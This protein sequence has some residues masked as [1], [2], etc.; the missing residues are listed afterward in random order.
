[1]T[2]GKATGSDTFTVTDKTTSSITSSATT[3]VSSA[4]AVTAVDANGHL[5]TSYAGSVYFTSSDPN[6]TLPATASNRYSF[7]AAD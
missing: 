6:A 3:N 5:V 1:V 7:T 4:P 2:P